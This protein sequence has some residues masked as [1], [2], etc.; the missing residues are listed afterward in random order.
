MVRLLPK[1]FSKGTN[2]KKGDDG[3]PSSADTAEG[4][5]G[6]VGDRDV[7]GMRCGWGRF[8]FQSGDTYE[9]EWREN[10][11]HGYGDAFYCSGSRYRG[12]W[13][14]DCK[15]GKGIFVFGHD[16]SSYTGDWLD[17][18]KTGYGVAVF[19]TA[20]RYAGQW[21]NDCMHGRGRF[22]YASGDAYEGDWL[23]NRKSGFGTWTSS[24][25]SCTY[26]GEWKDD[27]RH[28]AGVLVDAHGIVYE[29]IYRNGDIVSKIAPKRPI[30]PPQPVDR[31]MP[32]PPLVPPHPRASCTPLKVPRAVRR[33]SADSSQSPSFGS[34]P[35]SAETS[36][37]SGPVYGAPAIP[38]ST[39]N[40][41]GRGGGPPQ[42]NS[43][44]DESVE[45]AEGEGEAAL[46]AKLRAWRKT[47]PA[48]PVPD[49]V[50]PEVPVEIAKREHARAPDSTWGARSSDDGLE[51]DTVAAELVCRHAD[52]SLAD[53]DDRFDDVKSPMSVAAASSLVSPLAKPR[54]ESIRSTTLTACEMQD[55]CPV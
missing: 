32:E 6:Y 2:G 14:Q 18:K 49:L 7:S 29:V 8:V 28:G 47:A 31:S 40:A 24:D 38:L 36:I 42:S 53:C 10:M 11:K 55:D 39:P 19:R 35:N 46:L 15:H 4:G 50:V 30:P 43:R 45:R 5:V 16:G 22:V 12:D 9:G 1:F 20:N 51:Q 54:S 33:A 23:Q 34:R 27:L 41:D 48:P 25:S 21:L 44:G 17:D 52:L 26:A 13:S 37:S 3:R